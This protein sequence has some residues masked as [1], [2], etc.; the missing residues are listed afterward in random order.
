MTILNVYLKI[1]SI[2]LNTVSHLGY[3][4]NTILYYNTTLIIYIY[5]FN[6]YLNL[7]FRG[8]LTFR[9]FIVNRKTNRKVSSNIILCIH[10]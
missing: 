3:L 7:I 4:K 8:L 6:L 5:Y 2:F 1:L 10:G 9:I